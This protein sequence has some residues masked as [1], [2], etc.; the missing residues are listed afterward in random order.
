MPNFTALGCYNLIYNFVVNF[1]QSSVTTA[2]LYVSKIDCQEG[3]YIYL[4]Y[5]YKLF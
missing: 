5:Y 3:Y 1:W 2:I 4:A